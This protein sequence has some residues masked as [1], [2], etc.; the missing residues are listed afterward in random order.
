[1]CI[2]G[3]QEAWQKLYGEYYYL[4]KRVISC[5]AWSFQQ[6]EQ[7]ELIQDLFLELVEVLPSFR[8]Q[9]SLA[10]F[11]VQIAKHQC[12]SLLRKKTAQK[13]G[14]GANPVSM[15]ELVIDGEKQ[16]LMDNAAVNDEPLSIVLNK[17]ETAH[18][19]YTFDIIPDSCKEILK[20]RYVKDMSYEEISNS[21]SLPLGTVCS[22]IQR[23]IVAFKKAYEQPM[24]LWG[25]DTIGQPS[26]S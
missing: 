1:M 23:C 2:S 20:L 12:I 5:S 25:V 16:K 26:E 11:I 7:E 10:T 9:S 3:N 6:A 22:R 13:R 4:V 21:L 8:Q 17:E 24:V 18:L 14:G 15:E 19:K